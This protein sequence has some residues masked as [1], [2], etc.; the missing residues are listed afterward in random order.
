M[1]SAINDQSQQQFR[2]TLIPSKDMTIQTKSICTGRARNRLDFS[3]KTYRPILP[4]SIRILVVEDESAIRRIN[5]IIL[6]GFGYQVEEADDGLTAWE[7]LQ[8]N[9]YDLLLTD[10]QMDRMNGLD[11]IKNLHSARITLPIIIASGKM[12]LEEMNKCP[13]LGV[14][15]MLL[16][17]FTAK[18][19]LSTV[20][21]VLHSELE[22]EKTRIENTMSYQDFNSDEHLLSTVKVS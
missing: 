18:D 7:K 12:P 22:K 8:Q 4:Q 20:E 5:K 1:V 21:D 13:W 14:S 3:K 19:L 6:T 11:L 16:K 9:D 2:K 15:A 10:Y 17:P